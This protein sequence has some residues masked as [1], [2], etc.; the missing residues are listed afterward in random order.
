MIEIQAVGDASEEADDV[1]G[2]EPDQ[3]A[4]GE[5]HDDEHRYGQGDA[6][7]VKD[8][9]ERQMDFLGKVTGIRVD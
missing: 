8:A 9:V 6:I 7:I 3:L 5:G 2:Q 1:Q 4:G